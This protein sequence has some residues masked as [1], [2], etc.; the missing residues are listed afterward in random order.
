[1]R[2]LFPGTFQD[3]KFGISK[4]QHF[5]KISQMPTKQCMFLPVSGSPSTVRLVVFACGAS[6]G[7]EKTRPGCL[8][9]VSC[10]CCRCLSILGSPK[11]YR[12]RM[13]PTTA[14]TSQQ[15]P[16]PSS[17]QQAN[18]HRDQI[19]RTGDTNHSRSRLWLGHVRGSEVQETCVHVCPPRNVCKMC[20]CVCVCVPRCFGWR[21]MLRCAAVCMGYRHIYIYRMYMI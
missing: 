20:A 11:W 17:H 6:A 2:K 4:S 12:H 18:T 16:H 15:P 3:F 14:T 19:S 1:M 5:W 13:T 9:H 10:G 8:E 21:L 7:S